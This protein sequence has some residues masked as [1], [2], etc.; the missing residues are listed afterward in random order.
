MRAALLSFPLPSAQ[1]CTALRCTSLLTSPFLLLFLSFLFLYLHPSLSVVQC[2]TLLCCLGF[3]APEQSTLQRLVEEEAGVLGS[4]GLACLGL[5][6]SVWAGAKERLERE[7]RDLQLLKEVKDS[8]RWWWRLMVV[9]RGSCPGTY[10]LFGSWSWR[11]S[12][13]FAP[14]VGQH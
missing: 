8:R 4:P 3:F 13:I 9:C 7:G 5:L 14:L 1:Y 6:G 11:S 2:C 10:V 12:P